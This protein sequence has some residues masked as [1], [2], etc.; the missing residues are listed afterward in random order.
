MRKAVLQN[1]MALD[2]LTTSQGDMRVIIRTKCCVFIPSESSNVP[3]LLKRVKNQVKAL[4]D[5]TPS[6]DLFSWLPSGI[7]SLLQPRWQFL[8]LLLLGILVL[9]IIFKLLFSLLSVVRLARKLE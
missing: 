4:S 6:C 7:G 9:V 5:P 2:V 3:S 8:F 1:R